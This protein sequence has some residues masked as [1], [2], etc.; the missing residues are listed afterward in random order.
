MEGYSVTAVVHDGAELDQRATVIDVGL[1]ADAAATRL[2]A[3]FRADVEPAD[4]EVADVKIEAGRI[5]PF[6]VLVLSLGRRIR[7]ARSAVRLST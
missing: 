2:A 6:F 7:V 5:G 4:P 1:S 3:D